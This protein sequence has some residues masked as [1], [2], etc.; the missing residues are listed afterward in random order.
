MTGA[1]YDRIIVSVYMI[2]Y[3]YNGHMFIKNTQ[4]QLLL[5]KDVKGR[6]LKHLKIILD[7]KVLLA[8]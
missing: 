5:R 7:N 2:L 8:S 3:P 1:Y 4:R 6:A